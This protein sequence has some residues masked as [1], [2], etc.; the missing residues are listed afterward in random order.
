MASGHWTGVAALLAGLV[1]CLLGVATPW[2][3][4]VDEQNDLRLEGLWQLCFSDSL[5]QCKFSGR[6]SG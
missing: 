4:V 1:L 3:K 6:N 5:A 2:W